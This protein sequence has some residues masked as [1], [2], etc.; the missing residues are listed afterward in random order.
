MKFTLSWLKEHLDTNASLEEI[1]DKLTMIGLEVEEV[2]DRSKILAPFTIAEIK[3][4]I[5]HPNAEKLKLC[6][7]FTGKEI[8]QIVCGATNARN[9]LKVVLAPIDSIIPTNQ[10]KIKA[11]KI[12]GVES[13]GMLC[14]ARELGLGE[15]GEGIIELPGDAPIGT[16]FVEYAKLNDPVIEIAITPN[17]GDCLGVRGIARDLGASGSGVLK[18]LKIDS[19]KGNYKSPINVRIET[20]DQA[21]L[22]IGRYIK[23]VKNIESPDWLKKKLESIG[24]NPISALVDITNYLTFDLGRPAHV[25]DADKLN[26]N[27]KIRLAG[28]EKIIALNDKEYEL[29]K[30]ILVIA[31]DKSPV[32]IAGIIGSKDSGCGPNTKNIFLEIACFKAETIARIGRDLQINSDS[33]YRFERS[34]DQGFMLNAAEHTTKLIME[35]CGGEPS[36][37][38][39]VGNEYRPRTMKFNYSCAQKLTGIKVSDDK[40][41]SILDLLGFQIKEKELII[42]SWRNDIS[43]EEDIVEE[44][45]RIVG[46]DS[47]PLLEMPMLDRKGTKIKKS[48][49]RKKLAGRGLTEVVTFS[50]MDQKLADLFTDIRPELV[51]K[52]SISLELNYMRPSIIPNLLTALK[53]NSSRGHSNLNLFEIGPVFN[54]VAIDKQPIQVAG[55]R[56]GMA[57]PKNPHDKERKVDIY[58]VKADL[59]AVIDRNVSLVREAPKYYHPGR[60]GAVKLGKEILGYFGEIHPKIMKYMDITEAVVGFEL[61]EYAL[62]LRPASKKALNISKFQIVT[63]DFAFLVDKNVNAESIIKSIEMLKEGLIQ[64]I[65]IFDVYIGKNIP[66]GKKSFAFTI[67]LQASD[68]TLT[69]QEINEVSSKIIKSISEDVSGILR[70]N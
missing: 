59:L 12:R 41:K 61:T 11:T 26:G 17:R 36:E 27:L 14:S 60:S 68:R 35:I 3:E 29:N 2:V 42:P 49:V 28:N 58:D 39:V 54:G 45:A 7:V 4:A 43:I 22:F 66:E 65:E 20:P 33:R 62:N 38:V 25:Y 67:T 44:I 16:S 8:L 48:D 23:N 32:A 24:L 47:L 51:L 46:Y 69:D 30:D 9:G 56:S 64:E 37:L 10:M 6:Q 55:I 15:D 57:V 40:I 50:F 31:D 1:C 52:N 13:N 34:I 18:P 63:R 21:P 53:N 19:V 70:D 5:S